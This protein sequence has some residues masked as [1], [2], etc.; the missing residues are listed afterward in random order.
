MKIINLISLTFLFSAIPL[1]SYALTFDASGGYRSGS[2]AYETR[3]KV[4]NG[5][6][7]GWWDSL[8]IDS[9]NGVHNNANEIVGLSYNELET[10][11]TIPLTDK[12]SF[13]SDAL[14]CY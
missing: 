9:W 12:L 13:Y 10:N 7:N 3:L 14:E 2:H 5:W 6:D 4:S 1:T 11:Y 8:E